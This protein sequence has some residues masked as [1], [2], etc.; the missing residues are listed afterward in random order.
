MKPGNKMRSCFWF[1]FNLAG[2]RGKIMGIATVMVLLLG[3][4]L[5]WQVQRTQTLTLREQLDKQGISIARDV[6]ARSVDYIFTSNL[7]SLHELVKDTIRNNED[8]RYLFILDASGNVL[9]SSFGRGLPQGIRELNQPGPDQR[10]SMKLI[11]TEEGIIH[12]MAVPIFEGRAGVVRLG[13]SEQNLRK[14]IADLTR[15]LWNTTLIVSLLGMAAAYG[16]AFLITNPI[17][18]LVRVTGELANG[19]LGRR[20]ALDWAKDEIGQLGRSFNTMVDNLAKS[21]Q[22]LEQK[23]KMRIQLLGKVITAQEEERQ[24]I[25]RELHDQTGQVLTTLAIGLKMLAEA[26]DL[27][28]VRYQAEELRSILARTQEDIHDLALELRPSVLDD[29][30]LEAALQRYTRECSRKWG[31]EVDFHSTGLDGIRL[32]P[33][34]E[35]TVYRIVQEALTNIARH[36]EADNVSVIFERQADALVA[37]IEDDGKG[38]EVEKVLSSP[39]KDKKLGLFGMQERANLI[40]GT[41]TIESEPGSGTTIYVSVPLNEEGAYGPHQIAVG[42]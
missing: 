33:E 21:C 16:L 28:K 26:D 29:L 41:L 2:I 37:I 42:G 34:L 18:Q 3:L 25:A 23:E 13:M 11:D 35:T 38:F 22:E 10:Y 20:V 31:I 39:S 40:G 27:K 14:I 15:K 19:D 36:A 30:G 4:W 1:F 17:R 24:R 8:V 5:T 9:V 32:V 6:A 12:D 7:Y